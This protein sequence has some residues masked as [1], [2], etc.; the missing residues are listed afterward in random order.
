MSIMSWNCQGLGRPQSLTI[1]RLREM[2][3]KYFPEILFLMETKNC[4]DV[5]VDLQVWLG[6][7]KVYTVEPRGL[8]CGLT[9]FWKKSVNIAFK[10]ADKNLLDMLIQFGEFTFFYLVYMVSPRLMEE[11]MF[12]KDS[13]ELVRLERNR[14]VLLVISTRS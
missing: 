10:Y 3:Q 8:S 7:D 12:G 11:A 4:R 1:Q 6:Y 13:T 9:I 14:G 2:R 5:V